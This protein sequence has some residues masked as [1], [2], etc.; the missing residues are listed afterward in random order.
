VIG[1]RWTVREIGSWALAL[2]LGGGGGAAFAWARLPLPWMLGAMT[3]CT[4]TALSGWRPALPRSWRSLMIAVLGV[5]LGSAFTP[6]LPAQALRWWPS[7]SVLLALLVFTTIA[8]MAYLRRFAGMGPVTAYFAAAPGGVSEM[9]TTGGAMGGDER[10]IALSHAL[11]IMLIVFVVPVAF[12]LITGVRSAPVTSTM[13]RLLDMAPTDGAILTACLVVGFGLARLARLPAAG[14]FGPLIASAAVHMA[15]I[16]AS[17][18]PAELVIIAQVVT[19]AA[20]GCRFVGLSW[21]KIG[22]TVGVAVGS[23]AIMLAASA[24]GALAVSLAGDLPFGLLLLAF[25][26]GGIAEMSL[27][28]LALGQDVAFVS[29]HHLVR[30]VMVL[31]LAPLVFRLARRGGRDAP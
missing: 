14:L 17:R 13:G 22:G 11:R 18:P 26:P 24:G 20:I 27:I 31:G 5:M 4:V 8:G 28:A 29:T 1:D 7:L 3:A 16:T 23:T 15:G 12:R 30:V 2:I 19:G 9:V 6:G 21:R 10:S 25:V